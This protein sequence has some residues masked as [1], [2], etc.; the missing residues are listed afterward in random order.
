MLLKQ[1]KRSADA[2]IIN[3]ANPEGNLPCLQKYTKIK[4]QFMS[5][6]AGYGK[7]LAEEVLKFRQKVTYRAAGINHLTW[8]TDMI[9]GKDVLSK[10]HDR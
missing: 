10:L 3:Y 8:F 5:W 1:W 9:D 2:W 7:Q 4:F 6:N